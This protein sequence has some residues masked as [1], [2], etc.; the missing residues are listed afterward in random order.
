MTRSSKLLIILLRLA[1]GWFLLH[2]G[3][4]AILDSSWTLLPYI[5]NPGTF[6]S[7]Y[8]ALAEPALLPYISYGVKGLMVLLGGLLILGVFIRTAGF[9]GML[10]M[11][12][13]YFPLLRFPYAEGHYIVNQY[14][15]YALVLLFLCV[16][17][18]GEFFGL[19]SMFKF[20]RY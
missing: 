13:F 14:F 10:L 9:L 11:L 3:I 17:R 12:F 4:T 7:F 18:A 5:K 16:V 8:Q 6:S 19:A 1:M 2:W 20:S 15:V